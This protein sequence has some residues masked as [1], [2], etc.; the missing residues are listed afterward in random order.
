QITL[1]NIDSLTNSTGAITHYA[2]LKVKIGSQAPEEYDFFITDISSKNIIFRLLWLKKVSPNIDWETGKMM[3]SDS[4]E[5][6]PNPSMSPSLTKAWVKAGLLDNAT[7]KVYCL[8]GYTYLQKVT[9]KQNK[10]KYSKTFEL[11]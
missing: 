7:D 6:L 2:R 5:A 10:E 8:A 11:F 9:V 1:Q 3:L 4:S